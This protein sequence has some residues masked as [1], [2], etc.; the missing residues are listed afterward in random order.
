MVLTRTAKSCGSD[1]PIL[2][3]KSARRSAG[4]GVKQRGHRGEREVSRKTIARGMPGR[5]GVTVVTNSYACFYF[6]CEAAGALGARHSLRPLILWADGSCKPRAYRAAR[7]RSLV[8]EIGATSLRVAEATKQSILPLRG[9]MDCFAEPV[10]GRRGACHRARVRATRWRDPLARND[11]RLKMQP[12][13]A[14]SASALRRRCHHAIAAV[15]LGAVERGVGA[16]QH[17]ADGLALEFERRQSDR[18]RDLDARR[19]L[20]DGERLAGDRTPQPLRHH[21]GDVQIGLRHHDHK[22][23]AA[24]AAGQIDAADRLAD[25]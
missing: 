7:T 8:L 10:I 3:V 21:A 16:L 12:E 19:A 4:D 5:S 2:G 17:V 1:A 24:I 6:A 22:L 18:D 15:V 25:A 20:V 14:G 11:G 13:I 9:D 23:L